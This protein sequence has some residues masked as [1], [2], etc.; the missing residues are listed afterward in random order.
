MTQL[1]QLDMDL[2]VP[3]AID[4]V[5]A[6]AGSFD[7]YRLRMLYRG[8]AG[9]PI[10]D[11]DDA[12]ADEVER[13]LG[14]RRDTTIRLAPIYNAALEESARPRRKASR[15]PAQG[16]EWARRPLGPFALDRA[17]EQAT[18]H[19]F[20][21][22]YAMRLARM[23]RGAKPPESAAE[24]EELKGRLGFTT[25]TYETAVDLYE[26]AMVLYRSGSQYR[27]WNHGVRRKK[28]LEGA[29]LILP[30][31]LAR[32]L[33]LIANNQFHEAIDKKDIWGRLRCSEPLR[34]G[35]VGIIMFACGIYADPNR[36]TRFGDLDAN[37]DVHTS[38][39]RLYQLLASH[40]MSTSPEPG[41]RGHESVAT[42]LTQVDSV[43]L[44][45]EVDDVRGIRGDERVP[46]MQIP[47]TEFEIY[48][49]VDD[50]SG[51]IEVPWSD[52]RPV[53]LAAERPI[54]IVLPRWIKFRVGRRGEIGDR[55]YYS[56][57]VWRLLSPVG[58]AMYLDV[59]AQVAAKD[60]RSKL[61][62]V[63]W[64]AAKPW[65]A[66]FALDHLR[67][68]HREKVILAGLADLRRVDQRFAGYSKPW[69]FLTNTKAKRY[70][71]YVLNV[72]SSPRK[73]LAEKLRRQDLA[74]ALQMHNE[75][76]GPWPGRELQAAP[77]APPDTS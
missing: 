16:I 74:R 51:L 1:V 11:V 44:S 30:R 18:G 75:G 19:R 60:G 69:R 61:P 9:K 25:A 2:A 39:T 17:L 53:T 76:I 23:L 31:A 6:S 65:A 41:G 38:Q 22:M 20:N 54:R 63:Q 50:P 13:E 4:E 35:A 68:D 28:Q 21:R 5:F 8:F 26:L 71:V 15:T 42:W 47:E 62:Y 64:D 49:L 58:R 55:V 24:I 56:H 14:L 10:P 12:V 37:G 3:K 45:G 73:E 34:S 7:H 77:N 70:R 32:R 57:Q 48:K 29:T 52:E 40:S 59:R 33:P 72:A 46:E 36:F 66:R 67:D 43:K 27:E